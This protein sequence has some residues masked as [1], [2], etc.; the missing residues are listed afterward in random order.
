MTTI[1]PPTLGDPTD[2]EKEDEGDQEGRPQALHQSF[3]SP[4]TTATSSTRL[5]SLYDDRAARPDMSREITTFLATTTDDHTD[6]MTTTTTRTVL[7]M[8]YTLHR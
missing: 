6:P 2:R 7:D 5:A 4:S 8:G 1:G 3:D